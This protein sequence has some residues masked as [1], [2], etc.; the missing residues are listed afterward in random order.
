MNLALPDYEKDRQEIIELLERGEYVMHHSPLF[1]LHYSPHYRIIER[2]I[3]DNEIR[4]FLEFWIIEV[5][6]YVLFKY[7]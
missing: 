1:E 7:L 2:T 6:E 3:F 5:A 4:P